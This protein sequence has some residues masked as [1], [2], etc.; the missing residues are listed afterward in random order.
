MTNLS[1][2]G[3]PIGHVEGPT[4][5]IGYAQYAVDVTLPGLLRGKCLRSPFPYARILSARI[6]SIDVTQA[7][8]GHI[9]LVAGSGSSCV[10]RTD[11]KSPRSE[12][13]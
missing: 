6:L 5:V 11:R 2:I 13:Y 1:N 9:L 3:R 4:K 10:W 12:A 8:G 7:D